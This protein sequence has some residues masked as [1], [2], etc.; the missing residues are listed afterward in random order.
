MK[1]KKTLTALLYR[2]IGKEVIFMRCSSECKVSVVNDTGKA[3][4]EF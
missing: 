3:R 2:I 4:T 1:T